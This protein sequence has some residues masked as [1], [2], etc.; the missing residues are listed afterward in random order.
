MHR[1]IDVYPIHK[2]YLEG[3]DTTAVIGGAYLRLSYHSRFSILHGSTWL[4]AAE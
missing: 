4:K 3:R 1:S 2:L